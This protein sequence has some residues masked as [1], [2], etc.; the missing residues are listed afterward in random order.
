MEPTDRR[1]AYLWILR[2]GVLCLRNEASMMD[3][4]LIALWTDHLH[5]LPQY[6]SS[7][8][9]SPNHEYYLNAER[10]LFLERVE[11]FRGREESESLE[12]TIARFRE[13]WAIL[14]KVAG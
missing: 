2:W 7:P 8:E 6:I 3:R 13:A 9:A 10:K 11:S 5:N 12:F 1:S 4:E 14:E